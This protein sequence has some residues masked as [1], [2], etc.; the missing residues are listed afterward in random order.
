M[1]L[2]AYLTGICLG[3]SLCSLAQQSDSTVDKILNFPNR[4]FSKVQNKTADLN[5]QLIKQTEKYLARL[6]KNEKKIKRKL[7]AQDSAAAARLYAN[8]PEQQYNAL[9]QKLKNDSAKVMRSMGPE[10]LPYL[11]SMQGSLSFLNKNPQL[12]NTSKVFPS[13]IQNSLTQLQQL[14]VK[15]QDADQIKQ[16]IQARK[17]AIAGYL[18][19]YSHLPPGITGIFQ[20]YNKEAY[21]YS[22]QVRQYRDMLNDPDKMMQTALMLLNKLP[23][24]AS[25]MQKNS[26]L[27]GLFGIPSNYGTAEGLVGLQTRDQV[28]G[29]IQSQVGQGGSSASSMVSQ[30]LQAAQQDITKLQNKLTSLGGGSGDMDMP[31]F[32]PNEQKKKT[33]LQRLEFGTDIQSQHASYYFP[34]TT[35]LGF[36]VGYKIT[37]KN[38]IGVGAAYKIGWGTDINHVAISSQGAGLRSFFDLQVKKTWSASGG[39][40]LNYQQPFS[41]FSQIN[42][43][44]AWQQSGLI[45]I[46]K[47]IT[48]RSKVFTKTKLQLLWDFLSYYQVPRTQPIKFRVGYN[49]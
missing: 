39:Y 6:Q 44:N 27:A 2:H 15:M 43:L 17:A 31:N 41:Q 13:D 48:M 23:A 21:Y 16:F 25:F 7:Y 45:G 3:I 26:F 30:N 49:F 28:L 14:E 36:S 22:D 20:D 35:D 4:L 18:S 11:D 37:D 24:F 32:K 33:F 42:Y 34:T 5:K 29:M 12:L 1:K 9:M 19:Q 10:Y 46:T 47:T 8:D 38:T 40:E